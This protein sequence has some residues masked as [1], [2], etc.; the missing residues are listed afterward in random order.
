MKASMAAEAW[1]SG[2]E[3]IDR[4]PYSLF[5]PPENIKAYPSKIKAIDIPCLIPLVIK[6]KNEKLSIKKNNKT[7]GFNFEY[8][9]IIL[10]TKPKR[11]HINNDVETKN[12]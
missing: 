1:K 4:Y 11:I 12:N 8:P 9:A 3:K 2:A 10:D 5:D 7:N 6:S